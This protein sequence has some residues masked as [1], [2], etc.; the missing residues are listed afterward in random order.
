[1][2]QDIKQ[3]AK[4]SGVKL[5][6]IAEELGITDSAFSRKLRYE[7]TEDEKSQIKRIIEKLSQKVVA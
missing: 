1:M 7:L 4:K 5:W 6:K 2:N 3:A